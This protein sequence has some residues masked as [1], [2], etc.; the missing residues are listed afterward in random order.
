MASVLNQPYFQNEDAAYAKL[1]SIVW[2]NGAPC[3]MYMIGEGAF[4]RVP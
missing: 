3:G 4:D 1:E 2:P